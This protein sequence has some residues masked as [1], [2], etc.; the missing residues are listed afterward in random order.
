MTQSCRACRIDDECASQ[1][2]DSDT[3]SCVLPS[4]IV[5]AGPSASDT[6]PCTQQNPCSMATAIQT[7]TFSKPNIRMLPGTYTQPIVISNTTPMTVVGTGANLATTVV[8]T[9]FEVNNGA[10][11]T[12]RGLTMNIDGQAI[13]CHAPSGVTTL[14]MKQVSVMSAG[15]G[16]AAGNC[17]LT[18]SQVDLPTGLNPAG[19]ASNIVID[20]SRLYIRAD[21]GGAA[22]GGGISI[23]ITNSIVPWFDFSKAESATIHAAYT[24]FGS[25]LDCTM[26]NG[27]PNAQFEENIVYAPT[28][29]NAISGSAC[30]FAYNLVYPQANSIGTSTTVADPKFVDAAH[31]NFHLMVG[32][33]AIDAAPAG[34]MN[35]HDYDN[36]SRPQGAAN[37][38]GAFE[39]KP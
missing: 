34:T 13:W 32:S 11:V 9:G 31:G 22:N 15:Y 38:L 29:T 17:N 19:A 14:S 10:N 7:V 18:L 1:I 16:I 37:D 3:G 12:L 5:Y 2:C 8:A 28:A 24:T 6:T 21:A 35:G 25:A 27:T 39:Y 36:V 4:A 30:R 20:R 33:P 26:V 23:T